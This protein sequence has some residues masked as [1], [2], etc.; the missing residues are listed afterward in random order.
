MRK[1]VWPMLALLVILV[2]AGTQAGTYYEHPEEG[3]WWFVEDNPG[4][5]LVVPSTASGYIDRDLFGQKSV[6]LYFGPTGRQFIVASVISPSVTTDKIKT[7]ALGKYGH[8]FTNIKV[9]ADRT[10]TTSTGTSAYFYAMTGSTPA[11]KQGMVRLVVFQ[12]GSR[13]VYLI[14]SCYASD[15]ES[16]AAMRNQWLTAVNSF[17]WTSD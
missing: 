17:V 12:R 15:Y 2:S 13:F 4:Y 8:L 14:L 9:E 16:S 6:E 11:A 10:I 5:E 1:A 3:F 7:M